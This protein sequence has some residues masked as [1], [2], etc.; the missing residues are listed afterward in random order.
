VTL[1]ASA[2]T[3][4]AMSP[5]MAAY[6]HA[7]RHPQSSRIPRRLCRDAIMPRRARRDRALTRGPWTPPGS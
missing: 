2:V 4:G 7:D 3:C 1:I 5:L 6:S